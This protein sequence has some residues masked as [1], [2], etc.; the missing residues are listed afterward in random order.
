MRYWMPL[1]PDIQ[2]NSIMFLLYLIE[3]WMSWRTFKES[4]YLSKWVRGYKLSEI[5]RHFA[6]FIIFLPMSTI[7]WCVSFDK[8]FFSFLKITKNC[9][10]FYIWILP[11]CARNLNL[12]MYDVTVMSWSFAVSQLRPVAVIDEDHIW[13]VKWLVFWQLL[14]SLNLVCLS[15]R[16]SV[17]IS[18]F[19]VD[20]MF[21]GVEVLRLQ[22]CHCMYIIASYYNGKFWGIFQLGY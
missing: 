5:F 16:K 2:V 10:F 15:A 18:K 22:D 20:L 17:A 12:E 19:N 9:L 3:T 4:W 8:S 11:R 1:S 7:S 13:Q 14:W 21:N 6:D